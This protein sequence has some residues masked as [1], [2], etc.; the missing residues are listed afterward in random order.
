MCI[1]TFIIS[2][3][4]SVNAANHVSCMASFVRLGLGLGLGLGLAPQA[5]HVRL[6]GAPVHTA[7]GV[8]VRLC[9]ISLFLFVLVLCRVAPVAYVSLISVICII[10]S[11]VVE[12]T[13]SESE[14]SGFESESGSFASESLRKDSSPSP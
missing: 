13:K 10:L 14:S 6:R 1:D 3:K 7:T 11:D 5:S 9:S 4:V 12:S 8:A 2:I